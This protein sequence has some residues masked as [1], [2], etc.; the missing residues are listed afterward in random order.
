MYCPTCGAQASTA[1]NFCPSCGSALGAAAPGASAATEFTRPGLIT[2]IAILDFLGAAAMLLSGGA[3]T[4]VG[5]SGEEASAAV[6][7]AL[8]VFF[9]VIGIGYGAAGVGLMRLRPF[10]RTLQIILSIVGLLGFPI[11]TILS[12]LILVYLFNPGIKAMFSGRSIGELTPGEAQAVHKVG[13]GGSAVAVIVLAVV[14]ILVTVMVIGIIA[15]IAVPGLLRARMAG[16][17]ASAIGRIRATIS[18]E[19]AY[20]GVNRG[21]Y[22]SLDCLASPST[23]MPGYSGNRFIDPSLRETERLGYR[24]TFHP[25]PGTVGETRLTDLQGFAVVAVPIRPGNTGTRAFCGDVTGTVC[26]TYDGSRP[27]VNGGTCGAC[28]PIQ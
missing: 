2:A 12:I 5:L 4:A 3:V 1:G 14:G 25:Y 22:G 17:E 6:M 7:V 15:A 27:D 23:C 18:A 8:G 24:F 19:T 13:T 21:L 28:E 16:N 10:G 26:F 20:A 9:L 11:G